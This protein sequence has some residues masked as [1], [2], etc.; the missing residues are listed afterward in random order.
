[1]KKIKFQVHQRFDWDYW[2]LFRN[3]RRVDLDDRISRKVY[4]R[5]FLEKFGK[6]G[7]CIKK[8]GD[9]KVYS[10]IKRSD[11]LIHK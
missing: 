7:K 10:Y 2:S 11:V 6:I 1:M 3:G 8:W 5:E 4:T 9:G